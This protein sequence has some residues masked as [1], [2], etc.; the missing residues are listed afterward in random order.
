M[1][2][3]LLIEIHPD[4]EIGG[5]ESYNRRLCD[6]IN[7]NYK[8]VKI[9]KCCYF[10]FDNDNKASMKSSNDNFLILKDNVKKINGKYSV[11]SKG[12][13]IL[14]FRKFVYN[15]LEKNKY[16]LIIDSTITFFK[17]ICHNNNY[18]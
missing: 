17:K 8:N 14:R 18:F 9:D 15:L 6:I 12:F 5:A 1:K 2:R 4:C 3:V 13:A 10:D 11:F 7:K 16:D